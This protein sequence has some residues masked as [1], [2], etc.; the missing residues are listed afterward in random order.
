[1]TVSKPEPA[2]LGWLAILRA[3]VE[4]VYRCRRRGLAILLFFVLAQ[5]IAL[6]GFGVI[7]GLTVTTNTVETEIGMAPIG[8]FHEMLAIDPPRAVSALSVSF[9]LLCG[10][11]LFWPFGVWGHEPP[12]RRG[13]HWAMPV[14][15]RVHDLARV[16][17]GAIVLWAVV[18]LVYAVSI[19]VSVVSGQ[20]AGLGS[21]GPLFWAC[22]LLGPLLPYLL[23]SPILV[24]SEHPA[25]V[26][27][28]G[29]GAIALVS[30]LAGLT[31]IDSLNRWIAAF[32]VG[33]GGLVRALT[34]P[35][36]TELRRSWATG[37]LSL[38]TASLVAVDGLSAGG[39]FGIWCL[40]MVACAGLV[41]VAASGRPRAG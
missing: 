27:W 7:L 22:I 25:A 28:G 34:S 32:F 26:F 36:W 37:H 31:G 21:L 8:A 15:R 3:Q 13:Y 20:A 2:R 1:M 9:L 18:V 5:V 16:K 40:W 23:T 29:L 41:V 14:D 39:W 33:P 17:A 4:L 19:L 10:V 12:A 11:A 6:A 38:D 30:T 24:R 35:V